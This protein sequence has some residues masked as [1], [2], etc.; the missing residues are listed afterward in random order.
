MAKSSE[1]ETVGDRLRLWDNQ[2]RLLWDEDATTPAYQL[3]STWVNATIDHSDGTLLWSGRMYRT[4]CGI[5][6]ETDMR[7][8]LRHLLQWPDI[9]HILKEIYDS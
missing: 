2:W 5:Q 7:P 6:R 8:Y 1:A 4:P 9:K 3:I